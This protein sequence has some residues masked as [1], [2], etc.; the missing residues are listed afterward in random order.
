MVIGNE[1]RFPTSS[2]AAFESGRRVGVSLT[3]NLEH[4]DKVKTLDLIIQKHLFVVG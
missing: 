1:S 4:F 2:V 3:C